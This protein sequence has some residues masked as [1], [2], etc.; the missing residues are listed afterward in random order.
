MVV[1]FIK[2]GNKHNSR[3]SAYISQIRELFKRTNRELVGIAQ[4]VPEDEN[5]VFRFSNSTIAN[6]AANRAINA[7]VSSV[8]LLLTTASTQE[9]ETANG[10][11]S[12]M[13][14]KMPEP[15]RN[16]QPFRSP[17]EIET[18]ADTERKVQEYCERWKETV[19]LGIDSARRNNTPEGTLVNQLDRAL[20]S[21]QP[22]WRRTERTIDSNGLTVAAGATLLASESGLLSPGTGIYR[23]P[24]R[25]VYRL[26]MTELDT[27]YTE[28]IEERIRRIPIIV[29]YIWQTAADLSVCPIC[30]SLAG[31]YPVGWVMNRVHPNCRCYPIPIIMTTS[32][33]EE[34]ARRIELGEEPLSPEESVNY[35][36]QPNEGLYSYVRQNRDKLLRSIQ[37][38]T[39][40]DWVISNP[41][42]LDINTI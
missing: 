42:Y 40:Q 7:L 26:A 35:V 20:N 19:E 4:F 27:V 14:D 24:Y 17:R 15:I 31:V 23:S 10:L 11:I 3:V 29:G 30:S 5:R 8:I 38:G 18:S 13:L 36:R 2:E 1:D 9:Q 25:N 34:T 33:I 37:R 16:Y 39:V 32:E 22:L 41:Q 28:G 6:N 12:A 21:P